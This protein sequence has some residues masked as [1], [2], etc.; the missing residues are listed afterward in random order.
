MQEYPWNLCGCPI[1]NLSTFGKS[2]AVTP[3]VLGNT[4]L[5]EILQFPPST[6]Q[7]QDFILGVSKTDIVVI[8][9]LGEYMDTPFIS[10]E[11][12]YLPSLVDEFE[13]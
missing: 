9:L 6:N 12:A 13:L 10:P 3:L 7:K 4:P 1:K 2:V 8:I 11:I 5:N